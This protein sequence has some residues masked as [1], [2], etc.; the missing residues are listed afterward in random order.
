MV[1]RAGRLPLTFP[2]GQGMR[3]LVLAVAFV[4][5]STGVAAA[6]CADDLQEL[7]ARVDQ[8]KQRQRTP[9]T[10]AAS[11]A[12]HKD[13]ENMKDMDEVDCYNAIARAR[14]LL[15]APPPD[16]EPADKTGKAEK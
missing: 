14:K 2:G 1:G 15:A 5:G 13:N 16:A 4:I 11:A 3:A 6:S 10:I 9:Q 8:A 12:L 7:M